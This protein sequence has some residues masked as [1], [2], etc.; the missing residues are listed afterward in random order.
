MLV[1]FFVHFPF[2]ITICTLSFF[3]LRPV[4]G[5]CVVCL[6]SVCLS[7][8]WWA[9]S[10]GECICLLWSP[11]ALLLIVQRAPLST[12]VIHFHYHFYCLFSFLFLKRTLHNTLGQTVS[13]L[14]HLLSKLRDLWACLVLFRQQPDSHRLVLPCQRRHTAVA[15]CI[16]QRGKH[17][18]GNSDSGQL[19]FIALASNSSATLMPVHLCSASG[20][21]GSSATDYFAVCNKCTKALCRLWPTFFGIVN[22]QLLNVRRV[23]CQLVLE[24]ESGACTCLF[25]PPPEMVHFMPV[26]ASV[27]W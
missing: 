9:S 8:L 10:T 13:C 1:A 24:V 19:K 27:F 11:K 4:L 26:S 22:L 12:A 16:C 23:H 25:R 3:S 6:L 17:T 20:Q 2:S 14:F 5:S 7:L 18:L 21:A 15:I